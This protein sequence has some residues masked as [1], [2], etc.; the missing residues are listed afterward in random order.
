MQRSDDTIE[1]VNFGNNLEI[2]TLEKN[3]VTMR[4]SKRENYKV[5]FW[6]TAIRTKKYM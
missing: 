5:L 3:Y 4:K 1:K 2:S 6:I